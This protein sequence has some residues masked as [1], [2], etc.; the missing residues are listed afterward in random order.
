[1]SERQIQ[2]GRWNWMRQFLKPGGKAGRSDR[3]RAIKSG[4]LI[5]MQQMPF[6]QFNRVVENDYPMYMTKAAFEA[7]VELPGETR[8]KAKV[9]ANG[10][11]GIVYLSFAQSF[12]NDADDPEEGEFDVNVLLPTG[13]NVPRTLKVLLDREFDGEEAFVFLLPEES[14]PEYVRN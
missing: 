12:Q 1:M 7:C 3:T 9:P 5:D 2:L 4:R 6:R 8:T 13:F 14:W 10:R 11:W